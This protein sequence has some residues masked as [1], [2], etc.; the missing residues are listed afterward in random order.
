MTDETPD[1]VVNL[2]DAFTKPAK[3]FKGRSRARKAD[4]GGDKTPFKRG[5][6]PDLLPPDSPVKAL[7]KLKMMYFFLNRSG[8][9]IEMAAKDLGRL[10]IIA[11][12]GGN[13]YLV[14][15]WPAYHKGTD[16]PNGDFKHANLGP[17]LIE[18]CDQMGLFDPAERVREVGTWLDDDG[19]LVFHCGD[20]LWVGD[21]RVGTGLRGRYLYPGAPP[22]PE[23]L[24]KGAGPLN[25]A[26]QVLDKLGTWN[27]ARGETDARLMLG[28]IGAAMLGAAPPWRP[29]CWITARRGSGKSKLLLLLKWIFGA[30]GMV[31]SA[32][33]TSA[34]ITQRVANSSRPVALD[35]LEGSEDNRRAKDIIALARIAA[36]GDSKDRGS[37]GGRAVSFTVRN[38]FL[39]SSIMIPPLNAADRSRLAILELGP[40]EKRL[41]DV[42]DLPADD[43][44]DDDLVLGSRESWETVGRQLRA[45]LI[46]GWPRYRRTFRAYR[47]ALLQ[48]GHDD[49]GADQFGALGA[50]YDLLMFDALQPDQVDL[51]ARDLPARSM[52][53]TGGNESDESECLAHLLAATPATIRGGMTESVA[54]WLRKAREDLELKTL[55]EKSDALRTLAK[56]GLRLNPRFD[57]LRPGNA[58][59]PWELAIANTHDGLAKLFAGTKWG[60]T[61]GS[62]SAWPQMFRRLP[63]AQYRRDGEDS[64]FIR[65]RIDGVAKYVT[66]LPWDTIFPPFN[67][68][69]D[70]DEFDRVP[71]FA[72][73][74]E[75][76][77]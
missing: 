53:E 7:G 60:S 4:G 58:P 1:N 13:K 20:V 51:W 16:E 71:P 38:C 48:M 67:R 56:I 2:A 49:R 61:P 22:M 21:K 65:L 44:A 37:P 3:A 63:G 64:D 76:Q 29:A 75:T 31:S 54:H 17:V 74:P 9:L 14:Q 45:R 36:S 77:A 55:E 57:P 70:P 23:P 69:N 18:S 73:P 11:L 42:A 66:I 68:A 10:N 6:P 12:F 39:F 19:T 32:D 5:A 47:L 52:A 41:A 40:I 24:F 43:D 35:E 62:S 27:F 72:R 26:S 25:Q 15:H 30:H 8:E 59:V 34:A 50:A 46:K 28:W 33:A